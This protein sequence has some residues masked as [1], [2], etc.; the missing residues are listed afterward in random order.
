V[1]GR[2][3]GVVHLLSGD[4]WGGAEAATFHLVRALAERDEAPVSVVVLNDGELA[5]R[6]DL[7]GIPTRVV[8]EA[9]RSSRELVRAVRP[10]VAGA[11]LVHAHRRRENWIAAWSGRPWVAT[12]HGR[13]EPFRGVRAG[14]TALGAAADRLVMRAGARRVIAVSRDVAAWLRPWIPGSRIRVVPNGI[15]DPLEGRAPPAWSPRARRLGVLARLVPVK[16]VDLALETV[17]RLPDVELEVVGNGPERPR[18]EQRAREMGLAGRV[19]FVGFDPR[20]I[21][22]LL[23]WKVLLVTSLHEGHPINVLEA[24][25]AGTPV[26]AVPIPSLIDMVGDGGALAGSR[27]PEA[28]AR[29]VRTL[30]EDGVGPEASLGARERFLAGYDDRRMAAAVTRVYDE[31]RGTRGAGREPTA[32]A[33]KRWGKSWWRDEGGPGQPGRPSRARHASWGSRWLRWG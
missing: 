4:L 5:Q 12:R 6:L 33:G 7:A 20:P 1:S 23:T 30:L 2:R 26:A 22:R 28:L 10:H 25:A 14:R 17:A 18:L 13:P 32:R 29:T 27:S 9:H 21:R 16:D 31:V 15:R 24:M 8:P 19:R 11:D 3:G